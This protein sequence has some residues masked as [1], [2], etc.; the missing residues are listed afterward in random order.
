VLPLCLAP[1][2]LLWK[3]T[4][5]RSPGALPVSGVPS[6]FLKLVR[7]F[8]D[9][10]AT[11]RRQMEGPLATQLETGLVFHSKR[12][13]LAAPH[14]AFVPMQVPN[15]T[16]ELV[17]SAP[18]ASQPR[19]CIALSHKHKPLLFTGYVAHISVDMLVDSG[20]TM[21]FASSHWC[22]KHRFFTLAGSRL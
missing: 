16:D 13:L 10:R 14:M 2:G 17:C 15:E 8:K 5:M 3:C 1:R 12:D 4:P 22:Q 21:S 9:Q 18:E 6:P 20:A 7:V 19:I 11:Q